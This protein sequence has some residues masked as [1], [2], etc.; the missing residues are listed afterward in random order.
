[1]SPGSLEGKWHP[2]SLERGTACHK[3]GD[4]PL[5]LVL[6]SFI[7]SAQCSSVPYNFRKVGKVLECIQRR[8]AKLVGRLEGMSCE[9]LLRTLG[10]ST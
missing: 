6:C 4:C 1:M 9:E 8:A 7:C 10:F 5:Y 2:R 3:R